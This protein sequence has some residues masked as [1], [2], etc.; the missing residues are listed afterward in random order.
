VPSSAWGS[1]STLVNRMDSA[2]CRIITTTNLLPSERRDASLVDPRVRTR[3]EPDGCLVV[4]LSAQLSGSPPALAESGPCP[5]HCELPGV[6]EMGALARCDIPEVAALTVDFIENEMQGPGD[7]D[8]YGL[9]RPDP[10]DYADVDPDEAQRYLRKAWERWDAAFAWHERS[11][12][13][14][15]PHCRPEMVKRDGWLAR[16]LAELGHPLA[17]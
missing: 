1:F 4:P 10:N 12:G 13:H 6:F 5:Y 2:G 8:Y 3:L 15:C 7:S 11:T 9:R 14:W 17:S 16:H